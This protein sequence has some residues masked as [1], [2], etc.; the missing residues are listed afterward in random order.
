VALFITVNLVF[1]TFASVITVYVAPGAAGS[2]IPDLMAYF[3]NAD[4]P[5]GYLNFNTFIVKV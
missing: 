1:A 2:G 4:I 3:N 5:D